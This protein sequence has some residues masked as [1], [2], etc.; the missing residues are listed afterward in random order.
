VASGPK[1]GDPDFKPR[2]ARVDLVPI[3]QRIAERRAA[4][5]AH[6]ARAVLDGDTDI[7]ETLANEVVCL[8]L[9]IHTLKH[10]DAPF[11]WRGTYARDSREAEEAEGI[12]GDGPGEAA[13]DR[14]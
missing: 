3:R 14:G 5:V 10:G 12:L 4:A 7:M 8:R 13:G 11:D 6:S 2:Y 1:F 9:A